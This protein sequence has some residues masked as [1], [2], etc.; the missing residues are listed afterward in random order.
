MT[1]HKSLDAPVVERLEIEKS[2]KKHCSESTTTGIGDNH[3]ANLIRL[4]D[5]PGLL[6]ED[7]YV[8]S[9]SAIT[10]VHSPKNLKRSVQESTSTAT[11]ILEDDSSTTQSSKEDSDSLNMQVS[12]KMYRHL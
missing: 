11:E 7:G 12:E 5:L 8:T 10:D 6:N 3:K 1:N 2:R 4:F 9:V